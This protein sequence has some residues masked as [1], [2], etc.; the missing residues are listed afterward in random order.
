MNKLI[1]NVLKLV[2]LTSLLYA[3]FLSVFYSDLNYSIEILN[4]VYSEGTDDS[5]SS[6]EMIAEKVDEAVKKATNINHN[7]N[8]ELTPSLG[9]A[10]KL[11]AGAFSGYVSLTGAAQLASYVPHPWGKVA[12]YVGG[13]G[14]ISGVQK[15][16]YNSISTEPL[17]KTNSSVELSKSTNTDKVLESLK[18]PST[19]Q[20]EN[21]VDSDIVANSMYESEDWGFFINSVIETTSSFEGILSGMIILAITGLYVLT[22]LGLGIL[23]REL[24]LEEKDWVKSRPILLKLA[25]LGKHSS[26]LV[27]LALYLLTFF[28]LLIILI[29]LLY[30]KSQL[31]IKF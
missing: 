29:T 27:L 9:S 6:K 30:L 1:L 17:Y 14:A 31:P 26:R 21:P 28:C 5:S 20:S 12:V 3:L 11:A 18:V 13:F 16:L 25:T 22:S 8:V 7:V 2:I 10:L 15:L 23:S 19:T 24:R 4:T